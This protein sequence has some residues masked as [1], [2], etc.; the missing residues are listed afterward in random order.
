MRIALLDTGGTING[1]LSPQQAPP[2]HSR[3]IAWLEQEVADSGL[4]LDAQVL[5][6]KD[7]RAL[8]D[9]DRQ[10][11]CEAVEASPADVVLISH[12][13]YTMPETG[14]Y[15]Q[16]RLSA[17]ARA[18]PI[19]LLGALHPLGA[20]GS[21]AEDVLRYVLSILLGSPNGVSITAGMRLWR[22]D[23]VVKDAETGRFVSRHG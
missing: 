15:L 22:P 7:S 12:G 16:Q 14:C 21:D 18:R 13:T 4:F 5:C 1:I 2:A 3:V 8:D 11:L 19:I 9:A 23:S 17:S 20:P 6:M 10:R